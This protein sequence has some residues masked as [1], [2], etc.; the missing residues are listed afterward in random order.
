MRS[1][2]THII[3]FHEINWSVLLGSTL[4]LHGCATA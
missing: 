1:L 4:L 3:A 2:R